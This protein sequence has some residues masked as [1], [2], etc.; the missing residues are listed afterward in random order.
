MDIIFPSEKKKMHPTCSHPKTE[1]EMVTDLLKSWFQL[2]KDQ[3]HQTIDTKAL[4]M[5]GKYL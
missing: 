2:H 1:L 3:S 5:T 4:I